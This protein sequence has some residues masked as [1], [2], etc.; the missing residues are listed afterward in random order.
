MQTLSEIFSQKEWFGLK[1]NFKKNFSQ[2]SI[3]ILHDDSNDY[4]FKK[5]KKLTLKLSY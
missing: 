3:S 2:N 1:A 4:K 5:T